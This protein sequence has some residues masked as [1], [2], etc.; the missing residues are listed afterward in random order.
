MNFMYRNEKHYLNESG[1]IN[2]Y[3]FN[4]IVEY[5]KDKIANQYHI[6]IDKILVEPE[7]NFNRR[8][9]MTCLF[10]IPFAFIGTNK[11]NV[12]AIYTCN[13]NV[14][15]KLTNEEF[16]EAKANGIVHFIK[17]IDRNCCFKKSIDIKSIKDEDI[18]IQQLDCPPIKD[19][20]YHKYTN[21]YEYHSNKLIYQPDDE[22]TEQ[23]LY[24]VELNNCKIEKNI[25]INEFI[26]TNNCLYIH[27]SIDFPEFDSQ[28]TLY[29]AI[30]VREEEIRKIKNKIK[31]LNDNGNGCFTYYYNYKEVYRSETLL[32]YQ[33]GKSYYMVTDPKLIRDSEYKS[34]ISDILHMNNR[35]ALGISG[36]V[37]NI[38]P[39]MYG[40][41]FNGGD[42]NYQVDD[43][44]KFIRS[45]GA[46]SDI[47]ITD[48][49]NDYIYPAEDL[50]AINM[51]DGSQG[52]MFL[53]IPLEEQEENTH[54]KAYVK[55]AIYLA[56]KNNNRR[57]K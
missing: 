52:Y 17:G 43:N 45:I 30:D 46:E 42:I 31:D 12:T 34:D 36:E 40:Y 18:D 11:E 51:K 24:Y 33:V 27:P 7:Q 57:K 32:I 44:K 38:T 53:N 47:D 50:L 55:R 54:N 23:W 9:D 10:N 48:K 21:N 37:K 29:I 1:I 2:T 28:E 4:E 41:C 3:S 14:N 39:V 25:E 8:E 15:F 20:I 56:P 49:E 35:W 5:L 16:E 6:T 26:E 22:M 19:I 13:C